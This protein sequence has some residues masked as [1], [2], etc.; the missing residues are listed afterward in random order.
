MR[1]FIYYPPTK[2]LKRIDV[3]DGTRVQEIID[4]VQHEFGLKVDGDSQAKS[5]IVLNYNG[6]DLKSTWSLT[7]LGVP[8]GTI[9]RC[10]YRKKKSADLYVHCGFNSQ[11]LELFD[12]TFTIVT[13]IGEIRKKISERIGLPLSTFCLETYDS[14]RRLYD[15]MKLFQYD[16]KLHDHIY[17]KVWSGY[18]DFLNSCMK[19][20]P[21]HYLYDDLTRHY[22]L[23]IALHVA[24]FHGRY[25]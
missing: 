12:D 22:Q 8:P 5:S 16:L 20:F 15:Q 13:T 24:A 1:Y 11:I 17:L 14:K 7:D 21:K 18:E 9:I 2:S 3:V 6:S 10:L 4:M 23:Q 19:G 25:S